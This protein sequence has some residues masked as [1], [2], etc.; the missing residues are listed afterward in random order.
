[1]RFWPLSPDALLT[2]I[3]MLWIAIGWELV[4]APEGRK[5]RD[6]L[7]SVFGDQDEEG[8]ARVASFVAL[9]WII[10]WQVSG[11]LLFDLVMLF[12]QPLAR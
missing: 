6:W 2:G 11:K 1:M 5:A 10:G 7:A 8:Q 4:A 3:Q 9:C 12:W